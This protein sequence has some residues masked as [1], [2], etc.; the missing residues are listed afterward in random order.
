M[1]ISTE[2]QLNVGYDL[3]AVSTVR[4]RGNRMPK[5][6]AGVIQNPDDFKFYRS[7][8]IA[9]R[10]ISREKIGKLLAFYLARGGALQHFRLKDW[11]DFSVQHDGVEELGY[12]GVGG[13]GVTQF[14]LIKRYTS[15]GEVYS[16]TITKPVANTLA[17]YFDS[18]VQ[19]S[20]WSVDTATG[21]VGFSVAPANGVVI[22]A[23][24]E[25][26]VPAKFTSKN[27]SSKFL[28]YKNTAVSIHNAPALELRE[29]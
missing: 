4:Q 8:Q 6:I 22:T 10:N 15:G 12:L 29:V 11:A 19:S 13:A 20:G 18:V 1:N 21:L 5:V 9:T 28:A 16:R 26:D 14:Q 23:S 25:F 17:V 3:G 2:Q 24:F 27:F 7:W